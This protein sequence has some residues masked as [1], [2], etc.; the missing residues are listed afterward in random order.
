[1]HCSHCE[2]EAVWRAG[3]TCVAFLPT[4]P[5]VMPSISEANHVLGTGSMLFLPNH[6]SQDS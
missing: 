1:M 3:L 4:S 6:L 2:G 5:L